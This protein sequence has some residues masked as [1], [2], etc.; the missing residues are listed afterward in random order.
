MS[1]KLILKIVFRQLRL[2]V[3]NIQHKGPTKDYWSLSGLG[4]ETVLVAG[5][6]GGKD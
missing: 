1:F 3:A 6:K 2:R 5:L 4:S